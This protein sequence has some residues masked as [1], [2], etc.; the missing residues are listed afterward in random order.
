MIKVG[1]MVR[2]NDNASITGPSM[3]K[4]LGKTF[5]VES[6]SSGGVRVWDNSLIWWWQLCDVTPVTKF[7]YYIKGVK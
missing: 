6:I 5:E 1:D 3:K 4:M 7:K 2:I